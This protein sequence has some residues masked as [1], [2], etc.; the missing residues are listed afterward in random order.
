MG[1]SMPNDNADIAVVLLAAA[2]AIANNTC[3]AIGYKTLSPRSSQTGVS[4]RL[5]RQGLFELRQFLR[6]D[7][8]CVQIAED[9][10]GFVV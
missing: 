1:T 4:G 8:L 2:E 5:F 6:G 9:H 10:A 7:R 3:F